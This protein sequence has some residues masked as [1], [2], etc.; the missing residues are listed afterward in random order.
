[1]LLLFASCLNCSVHGA[2]LSVEKLLRLHSQTQSRAAGPAAGAGSAAGSRP[3]RLGSR[4]IVPCARNVPSL[5]SKDCGSAGALGG[6][7]RLAVGLGFVFGYE[8]TT[9]IKFIFWGFL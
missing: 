8:T 3:A 6:W 1:M 7:S 4:R 9:L 2:F 5:P